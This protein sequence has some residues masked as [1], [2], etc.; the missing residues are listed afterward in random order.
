MRLGSRGGPRSSGSERARGRERRLALAGF[1]VGTALGG[2]IGG[3]VLPAGRP[4]RRVAPNPAGVRPTSPSGPRAK[5]LQD[6]SASA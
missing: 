6:L 1:V 5:H 3:L 2:L 4:P